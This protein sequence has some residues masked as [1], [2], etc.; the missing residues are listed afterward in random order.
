[1]IKT[2]YSMFKNVL[3][4]FDRHQSFILTTHDNSDP[5]G[6]GSELVLYSILRKKGKEVRIINSSRVSKYFQFMMNDTK[7]EKWDSSMLECKEFTSFLESSAFLILDT[8]DEYHLGPIREIIKN[9]K[10]VFVFDHHEPKPGS[11]LSGFVDPSASS[12]SELVVE[13]ICSMGITLDP[14]I[15]SAVYTGLVYDSGF[16][17][18]PKTTSRTFKAALKTLEWGANPNYIYKQLMENSTC[19]AIL[20]QKHALANIKFL[21]NN[22]IA[23]MILRD[24][25]FKESGAEFDEV[26]NIVNIPLR[27]KEVEVSLLIKENKEKSSKEISCSLRSKGSINVSKIAQNF[28]GGGHVTAAGFRSSYSIEEIVTILLNILESR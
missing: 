8:S 1:M 16:F 9:A 21:N 14:D 3:S 5:D 10:E 23:L 22:K 15:A 25:D 26:E 27:A 12:T 20:L 24:E 11:Q 18:Y 28:G 13:L 17:S 4:F 19:A 2:E 7:I 6:L